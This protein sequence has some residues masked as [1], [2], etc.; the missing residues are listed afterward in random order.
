MITI[1]L[2]EFGEFEK[3][4]NKPLFVAGLIFDDQEQ[5]G[6]VQVEE[7][8]ERERVRAYYRKVIEDAGDGFSYPQDLHSNGDTERDHNVI[9][10]VKTKVAETLPEFIAKG[11]YN[12]KPLTNE[13]G[14]RIRDRKGK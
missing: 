3:E 7:W 11:T 14:N 6:A 1:S 13:N 5:S 9:G 2:D 8:T 12:G 10:P 4:D